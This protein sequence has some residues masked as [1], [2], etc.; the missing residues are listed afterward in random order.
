MHIQKLLLYDVPSRSRTAAEIAGRELL[1][2]LGQDLCPHDVF[3]RR[4]ATLAGV[5]HKL[6]RQDKHNARKHVQ[7][8][9]KDYQQYRGMEWWCR[10]QAAQMGAHFHYDTAISALCQHDCITKQSS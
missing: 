8:A 4:V 9:P 5:E 10:N 3:E 2:L 6:G 1:K 7:P